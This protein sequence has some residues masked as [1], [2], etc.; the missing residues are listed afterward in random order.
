[1]SFWWF[2]KCVYMFNNANYRSCKT[3]L[4]KI[5]MMSIWPEVGVAWKISS[6][7]TLSRNKLVFEAGVNWQPRC[8]IRKLNC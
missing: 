2:A 5:L 7:A 3:L 8:F 1:M 6:K 4:L